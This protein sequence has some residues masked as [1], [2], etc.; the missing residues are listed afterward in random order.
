M[1]FTQTWEETITMIMMKDNVAT[2]ITISNL[3][4]S[5]CRRYEIKKG[6]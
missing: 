5:L 3:Q 2:K 6:S 4:I 1:L